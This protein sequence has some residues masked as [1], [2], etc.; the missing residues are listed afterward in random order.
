M[1]A[2]PIRFFFDYL[3]P[4]SYLEE[5]ELR[6]LEEEGGVPEVTR[7]PLEMRPPPHPLLDPDGEEWRRLWK[8]A[9]AAAATLGMRLT[10]PT[11]VPWT[12]KAH[13]LVLHAEEKGLKA[14]AHLAVFEA[15]FREGA[16][17]GR[18][19]VLV[20]IAGSLG[21]DPTEAKVV[22]DVDRHAAAVV[23]LETLTSAVGV[24]TIPALQREGRTLQGF[25]NRDALRTFLCFP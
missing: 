15:V 4:F 7:I 12:R 23:A 8:D 21:M 17:V 1:D 13:E 16:D 2:P 22:L 9:E 6:A 14:R 5:L 3:D 25:H 10:A 19:D 20:S 11:M 18:V 24:A